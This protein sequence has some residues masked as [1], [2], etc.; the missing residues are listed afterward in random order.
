MR[1]FFARILLAVTAFVIGVTPS[2]AADDSLVTR[3]R[4]SAPELNGH[5]LEL[6]VDAMQCA[7]AGGMPEVQRLAVID[8]SRPSTEPRLWV[9]NL[10]D[11]RVLFHEYV[12]HGRNSGDNLTTA[13]SNQPE[14]RESSLGLFRTADTYLG[15]N[16]YSLHMDGLEPGFNDNARERSIV[17]HGA[18]YVSNDAISKMGRLGRSWGCPAVRM[19]IARPMIDALKGGQLLF[20]YYPDRKWL[21]SS[22]FLHCPLT[23]HQVASR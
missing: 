18:S 1:Y 19:G 5:V 6:A 9:F 20:A 15:G 17:M 16:G 11:A 3:L 23:Q 12:A 4:A 14:S 10:S 13:F 7:R 8:Y 2:Y 21:A 22:R